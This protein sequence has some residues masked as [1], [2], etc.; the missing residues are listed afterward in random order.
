MKTYQQ[1]RRAGSSEDELARL[2]VRINAALAQ[3]PL[4]LADLRALL[5]SFDREGTTL[6]VPE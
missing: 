2:E 5:T 3:L 4:L 1:T 6:V